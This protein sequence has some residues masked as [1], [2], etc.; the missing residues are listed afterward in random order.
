[1]SAAI[2]AMVALPSQR[3]NTIVAVGF[4]WWSSVVSSS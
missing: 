3:P 2:S 1:M 4:R